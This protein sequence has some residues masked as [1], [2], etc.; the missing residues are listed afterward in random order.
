MPSAR[1]RPPSAAGPAIAA[2]LACS[3]GSGGSD[4]FPCAPV[5]TCWERRE[6]HAGRSEEAFAALN[7]A[8]AIVDKNDNRFH[9]AELYRLKGE[10]LLAAPA[11]QGVEAEACFQRAMDMARRQTSKSWELRVP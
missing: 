3:S 10:L 8:L 2:R 1:L 5:R 4:R 9:E 6:T 11:V 7:E